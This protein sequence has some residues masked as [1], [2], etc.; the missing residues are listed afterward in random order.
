MSTKDIIQAFSRRR[1]AE[2][3]NKVDGDVVLSL[4]NYDCNLLLK[5]N[6][7]SLKE[8]EGHDLSSD[9]FSYVCALFIGSRGCSK[10]SLQRMGKLFLVSIKLLKRGSFSRQQ[11]AELLEL[12]LSSIRF[13]EPKQTEPSILAILKDFNSN[14]TEESKANCEAALQLV[15]HL[16]A[17]NGDIICRQYAVELICEMKFP[18]KSVVVLASILVDLCVCEDHLVRAVNKIAAHIVWDRSSLTSAFVDESLKDEIIH[19]VEPE[20][21]PALVYQLL[22][23]SRKFE[24]S[25]NNTLIVLSKKVVLESL[26]EVLDKLF[27]DACDVMRSLLFDSHPSSNAVDSR[28]RNILSTIIHHISLLVSKDQGMSNEIVKLLRNNTVFS[29]KKGDNSKKNSLYPDMK[30]LPHSSSSQCTKESMDMT[31]S[32][33]IHSATHDSHIAVEK[34]VPCPSPSRLLLV[35]LVAKAPR[36]EDSTV[37][38]FCDCV[39]VV[40]SGQTLQYQ[41]LWFENKVWA[42]TTQSDVIIPK[43]IQHLLEQIISGPFLVESIL[44]PMMKCAC[45]LLEFSETGFAGPFLRGLLVLSSGNMSVSSTSYE[46]LYRQNIQRVCSSSLDLPTSPAGMGAWLMIQLFKKCQHASVFVLR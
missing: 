34:S 14:A 40:Y 18:V 33:H 6:I 35:F 11:S 41:S 17:R 5:D 30:S 13:L 23:L 36:L 22:C 46:S 24:S 4:D 42:E 31:A 45:A 21:L 27:D 12:M 19:V 32:F 8:N 39:Q 15:P 20:D 29:L 25:S 28:I 43:T 38:G 1:G 9:L 2:S 26:T 44:L 37:Q 7:D 16:V 3:L 10:E